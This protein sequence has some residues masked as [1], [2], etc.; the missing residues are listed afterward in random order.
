MK[1]ESG[2]DHD[3]VRQRHNPRGGTR[4]YCRWRVETVGGV[5]GD[6]RREGENKGGVG[7]A[8]ADSRCA[9]VRRWYPHRHPKAP[10]PEPCAHGELHVT[11]GL[12]RIEHHDLLQ[13]CDA[14][15]WILDVNP[16]FPWSC[17]VGVAEELSS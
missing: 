4:H 12:L 13:I 16:C 2:S 7:A 3:V 11:E 8:G 14:N 15:F 9:R 5:S 6:H 10:W 17:H 1:R